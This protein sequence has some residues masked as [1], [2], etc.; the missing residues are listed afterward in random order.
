MLSLLL[1]ACAVT[2]QDSTATLDAAAELHADDRTHEALEVLIDH[3][4][5][6][7]DRLRGLDGE[8]AARLADDLEV[9]LAYHDR[10]ANTVGDRGLSREHAARLDVDPTHGMLH[11]RLARMRGRVVEELAP[12][13]AWEFCGPF[14]N[15]RG[16][17]MLR[18]TPA[19]EDPTAA[20]Y[21]GKVREVGW[22]TLPAVPPREGIVHFSRLI[23]P[24]SQTCVIARTWIESPRRREVLLLLGAGEEVRVWHEGKEVL[25]ALGARDLAIDTWGVPLTLRA[26]W[27]E[28]ALQVGSIDGAPAFTARLAEAGSARPLD[29][30]AVAEAPEG[31]TPRELAPAEAPPPPPRPGAVAR[32]AG[33]EDAEGL[34]RRALLQQELE[35]VPRHER[36]GHEAVARARALAPG[37]LRYDLLGLTTLRVRG[38]RREEEH[39]DPWLDALEAAL[40]THGPRPRLLRARARHAWDHQP[41]Y[42]R[43]LE[44]LDAVLEARPGDVPARVEVARVLGRADQD[45]LAESVR[46]DL[47]RDGALLPWPLLALEVAR[48]LP[49]RHPRRL[50]LLE[51]ARAQGN[52]AAIDLARAEEARSA[53]EHDAEH[54]QGTLAETL[55]HDPWSVGARRRAAETLIAIAAAPQA[56]RVLDEALEL[57][58]DRAGLHR[59]RARALLAMDEVESATRALETVLELD[60]AEEDERRLLEHLRAMGGAPFHEPFLEPLDEVLARNAADEIPGPEVAPREV[61]L[62]RL[63]V[64]VQPDGTAKRYFRRVQRVL[65]EAGARELDRRGFRVWPGE[66][67][68][69]V[70]S[71]DVRRPDGTV[72]A[73]RTGR[74][75]RRGTVLV[76]L[77]PL[78]AGDVVDLQWRRDDLRTTHFGNYFGLDASFSP[79][80]RLPVRESEVVLIV[81]ESFPV[82][83]NPRLPDDSE[84][85]RSTRE[86]GALVHRWVVRGL[87]PRRVERYQPPAREDAPRV[88]ASSYASWDD[89]GRWWWNLIEDEIRVSADMAAKVEELTAD[90]STPLE[91]LRAVYDFVVTEVRYNAWEFGV[92]GYQ[93]YSAPVIFGR[94]FG[95]CKDK[96]ILLK[97]MLSAVDLEAWPVLIRMEP[98][99]YEED[100]ELALVSHFNHCIAYVPEQ[101]GIPEMYLD[102]TARLHPLEVLPGADAGARVL[103]VE[104]DGTRRARVPFPDPEENLLEDEITV[105]LTGDGARVR[106]LR[107]PRG[108][109]DPQ[110]RH[111]FTGNP[112]ERAEEVGRFLTGLFGALRGE[113]TLRA[114]DFEDLKEPLELVFEAGVEEVTRPAEDGFEL[115]TSFEPLDL[116]RTVASET[117]RETDLLLDV[118]W[119]RR[120]EMVYRLGPGARP[121]DLPAPV[122]VATEDAR[123]SRTVAPTRDGVRVEEHFALESHRVPLERYQDFRELC[124]A[125]DT[126]QDE[127][128]RVEVDQ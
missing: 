96:A 126:A 56:L 93:P 127:A 26:G 114:G 65:G 73:A 39:V 31:L 20:T 60:Y 17:G 115:P 103:I 4:A 43:A 54:V 23:D 40:A 121:V 47:A 1:T 117:K 84:Y 112:E 33:A 12:L 15:E 106:L 82:T 27:N 58:P 48:S 28:L 75:G 98:R 41:T 107:R 34:F 3:A 25:S 105:D 116:L 11:A 63:V 78:S 120:T 77:P 50:A 108:R 29:L 55:R 18:A 125:V 122:D 53:G 104:D 13:L 85:E 100:H 76:D 14:D 9:V 5:A 6:G 94:R 61:L 30:P 111:R 119:S 45:E 87:E 64:E 46:R 109:W 91:E 62:S 36:P 90:A 52:P 118:P 67:E 102:G 95:D 123:Y 86:D 110:A 128:V 80:A 24:S 59:W 35:A 22:R 71:A 101:E 79:D 10:L 113:P 16:Q 92:H 7:A 74:T 21:D 69:R 88:Q 57:A 49:D 89:F 42:A 99:R 97:A 51:P 32:Y 83:L 8:E 124:R 2:A 44:W 38:A 70:L 68:V 66:E 72:D 37:N 19:G 81:P